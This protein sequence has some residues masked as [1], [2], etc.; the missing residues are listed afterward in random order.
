MLLL[1]DVLAAVSS[2]QTELIVL[3]F[4]ICAHSVIFGS[5]RWKP[6]QLKKLA[7]RGS[8]GKGG[9]RRS[10]APNSA[11]LYKAP[12]K[13]STIAL[14]KSLAEGP[15]R[16]Q[17][18]D[19]QILSTFEKHLSEVDVLAD[20][21]TGRMVAEVALRQKRTDV[22]AQLLHNS[23]E[24]SRRVALLKSFGSEQRLADATEVFQ[25][26]PEKTP[27]LYNAL[28]DACIDCQELQVADRIMAEAVAAN[29]ADVVTYNTIIKKHLQHGQFERVRTLI[30]SMPGGPNSVTFNELID[31]TIK[32]NPEGAWVL[33]DE[34]R[35]CG[36]RP[37]GV[38]C[39][40]LLKSIQ[41][42]SKP[43]DVERSMAFVDSMED[44]M[45]EVLLSS[46]CEACI[47][48]GRTDLLKRQ[49]QRQR[50]SKGVQVC[51]AHTF[52]SI[53]RAYGFLKDLDGAWMAWRQMFARSVLP[54]SITIGC[55]V[56]ALVSNGDPEGG[57]QLIRELAAGE[58]TRP[59]LNAIIY[60][61]VLKG[62]CHHK[63]F[64]RVWTVY[65]EMVE[66][67]LKFSIVTFNAVIDACARGRRMARVQALLEDMT[68]QGIEPNLVTHSTIL[69]GYCQDGRL[70]KA[71][72]LLEAMKKNPQYQPDEITYNTI[73]DGCAHCG[74]FEQGM[75]ILE[76]MQQAGV[77][78]STFTLSVLVKLA[79]RSHKPDRA[80]DLVD[81]LSRRYR[82]QPN[83]HVFNNLL[84][85]CT[86]H[87][88]MPRARTVLQHMGQQGVWPD[89]RTYNLVLRGSLA[90]GNFQECAGLVRLACGL[91]TGVRELAALADM[92]CLQLRGGLPAELVQEVLEA[93]VGCGGQE[94]LYVQLC[95]DLRSVPGLRI[96]PKF[97]M[98]LASK[99]IRSS[100]RM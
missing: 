41:R 96:D 65:Q 99:M 56:E 74:L 18:R 12:V 67:K 57:Y 82:L 86:A 63:A 14:L 9:S 31:A 43:S 4:A 77:S 80:F 11:V 93:I 40:I 72:E 6:Q 8:S 97:T 81:E 37:T 76:E 26:C 79:N 92:P 35:A 3:V 78:P 25:A 51:G 49:L 66:A 28:L 83:V 52:G 71:L 91:Q 54:T 61:S 68:A 42:G 38:T 21:W 47:R 94:P 64:D 59:L 36:L 1:A 15:Q 34:M 98:A 33:L 53:I 55:M 87:S 75:K 90:A 29:M 10:T 69:K 50:G 20:T 27:C 32:A 24:S 30:E 2:I 5:Y 22:L 17:E 62:F 19:G 48:V 58:Q 95:K 39:S 89:L 13:E 7:R 44:A 45:D 100:G 73:I 88:D 23:S 16:S 60:C 85:V 46:F 70:D 84:H